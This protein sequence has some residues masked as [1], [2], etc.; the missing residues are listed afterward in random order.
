MPL[1]NFT[2]YRSSAGSGKTYTLTKEY[3]K[4]AFRHP[5]YYR[6]ILAVTFTNKATREMKGRIIQQLHL[7]SEGGDDALTHELR[8]A[9]NMT[10][11]IMMARAREVL[12]AIL[13]GY[14]HF[15][16]STI[17]SFFQK[18]IRS[19]AREMGLQSGFKIEL[20]LDKVLSEVIDQVLLDAGRDKQLT[21][22][23]I[24]FA[25]NKV[26]EGKSWDFR[27]D[28]SDLAR[29]VF[30]ERFKQYERDI[31]RLASDKAFIPGAMQKM[32]ALRE[33]YESQMSALGK[34]ALDIAREH[35]LLIDDFSYG[36]SGAMGYLYKLAMNKSYEPG[37]RVER[38]LEQPQTWATKSSPKKEL[39]AAAV[40]GGLQDLLHEAIALYREKHIAYESAGQALR[41]IYT[42]GILSD[43]TVKLQEYRQENSV[44]LISD[45][46]IFLKDI[47][48]ENEAPFIYEKVGTHYSHF[49]IDEF[50]DTSAFQWENFK[51]LVRNSLAEGK[52]NLVVGDVKQSI[53]RWRGGDWRLLLEQ[54]QADA[55]PGQ[56][57]EL[58]LD[59][60]WRSTENIIAFNNALF[61]IAPGIL[62]TNCRSAF[63]HIKDAG[64]KEALDQE[65]AKIRKAYRDVVQQF[66][67]MKTKTA[68]GHIKISLLEEQPD[69]ETGWKDRV[70]E[71]LPGMVEELQDAGYQLR[72]I[73]FLVRSKQEGKRIADTLL[74]HKSDA[75]AKPGY[76]YDVISPESLYLGSNTIVRLLVNCL[77]Y[78]NNP[79][80]KL[81]R[82]TIVFGYQKYVR[83]N[84]QVDV[85]HLLSLAGDPAAWT[86]LLP[87]EFVRK[88]AYLTK[89][90]LY[91]LVE[92]L[93]RCFT[94]HSLEPEYPYIQAFMD[95]VLDFSRNEKTDINAF[96]LWW[97]ERGK[98]I[99]VQVSEEL[100]AIRILTIHKSKGLQF[101]VV[102]APFCDWKLGHNAT[103]NNILWC[104]TDHQPLNAVKYLPLKYSRGLE[105]T[106]YQ[107]DYY[108]EMIQAQLDALNLL[109]VA[110]T[111]AEECL[112]AF[113]KMPVF[114]KQG[115]Y[116][117][118][119][120]SDLLYHILANDGTGKREEEVVKGFYDFWDE[121]RTVFEMGQAGGLSGKTVPPE[122]TVSLRKFLSSPWRNKLAIKNKSKGFFRESG[123]PVNEKI[124]YGLLIHEVL[125][126][127]KVLAQ[128]P[129]V[130]D[131]QL[132]EGTINKKERDQL[133]EKINNLL[134]TGDVR[135]WFTDG[136]EVRTEVSVL[137]TSGK[138]S[139]FDRVMIRGNKAVVVDFKLSRK[140]TGYQKQIKRYVALLREMG[141]QP[142]EGY[143][144]Y[145]E[146]G[147]VERVT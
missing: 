44:M 69:D 78:L 34:R 87:P 8:S 95:T 86:E 137:T 58:Q 42:F 56:S 143:L 15:S 46:A 76:A 119:S 3:L 146:E 111:R 41:F 67:D 21:R 127:I 120:A 50:Q 37:K 33:D 63:G 140:G 83:K 107:R 134:A 12:S 128:I 121:E 45:A 11:E 133:E 70:L 102:I 124:N 71:K 104:T 114:D 19:F 84:E 14:A 92:E 130:L 103:F 59:Q 22:W 147:Q 60:N 99:A 2:I 13:H 35:R 129:L 91:E 36:L 39:I 105:K 135:A 40:A 115:K 25:E 27:G 126:R 55:G 24:R 53:Y 16:V 100:N 141:Y 108:N 49:L 81:A 106:Y 125:S 66:P 10:R 18:V 82:A 75:L 90:P 73:A 93:V 20:D 98:E 61:S 28:I 136:W 145:I 5:A 89:L 139:R 51:P 6:Q 30:Q 77:A 97:E 1:E 142:V 118:E 23:L 117:I 29:E 85:H 88:K 79:E 101:K 112:Y 132:F 110:F 48:G 96:L 38:A 116:K 52:A 17:D 62:E 4:L 31:L 54:V 64:L 68:G 131:Q 72:D 47:I 113:G 122:N 26:E 109:Y 144:L 94:L 80:D 123:S 74:A 32:T 65:A 57:R 138:M 9:L 7:I 43:I